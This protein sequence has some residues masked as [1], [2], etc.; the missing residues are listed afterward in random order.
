VAVIPVTVDAALL[1]D[2]AVSGPLRANIMVSSLIAGR[3]DLFE[4]G[5][6]LSVIDVEVTVSATPCL[7]SADVLVQT[8]SGET[9]REGGEVTAG[10]TLTIVVSAFDFMRLPISR[11]ALQIT[12]FLLE[13]RG[14]LKTIQLQHRQSNAYRGEVPS[15]WIDNDGEYSLGIGTNDTSVAELR[16]VVVTSSQSL[17]IGIGIASVRRMRFHAGR[18]VSPRPVLHHAV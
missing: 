7:T 1:A 18:S 8:S 10:D 4:N 3:S 2:T 16:F 15:S 9:L 12:G 5:T 6:Q 11:P 17:Y 14:A 13:S